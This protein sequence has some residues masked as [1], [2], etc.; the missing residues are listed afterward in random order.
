MNGAI[1]KVGEDVV[2]SRLVAHQ[3]AR[4]FLMACNERGLKITAELNHIHYE[5][6]RLHFSNAHKTQSPRKLVD[7]SEHLIDSEKIFM[8]ELTS[9]DVIFIE[10]NLPDSLYFVM[11][12]EG[13][14]FG[15]IMHREAT[16]AKAI[17][18]LANFWGIRQSEIV[19]FG[20]DLNDLDLL[21][22]A[23]IGVAMGNAV[24]EVKDVVDCVCLGNDEDGVARWLAE[25]VLGVV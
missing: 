9:E 11:S 8:V 4:P 7:F 3:A 10:N 22:F 1:A 24:D 12:R 16:K 2:Y 14:G 23:G 19:A 21:E 13:N 20:D 6:E 25:N 5:N 15:M 18:A 17:A